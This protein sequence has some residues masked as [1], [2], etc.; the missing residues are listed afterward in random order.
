[1]WYASRKQ[2][3]FVNKYFAINTARWAGPARPPEDQC[4]ADA[5]KPKPAAAEQALGERQVSSYP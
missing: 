4:P 5:D 1:M 2:P 3:P